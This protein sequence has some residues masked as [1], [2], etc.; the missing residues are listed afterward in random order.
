MG[1]DRKH[2][3]KLRKK[4]M[5]SV[6]KQID[7][8]EEKIQTEKGRKDTTRD[9]WRKEIDEKFL[10]KIDEDEEYLERQ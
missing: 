5:K 9:Y 4:R 8:H 1:K 2:M 10:K 7:I 6:Q 3:K